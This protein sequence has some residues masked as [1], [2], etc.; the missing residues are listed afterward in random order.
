MPFA[1]SSPIIIPSENRRNNSVLT[2]KQFCNFLRNFAEYVVLFKT[3][4]LHRPFNICLFS[5]RC[6]QNQN[7]YEW[8][9]ADTFLKQKSIN[10]YQTH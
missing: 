2:L 10:T 6:T 9:K 3:S 7:D 8:G 4:A 1:Q 5:S